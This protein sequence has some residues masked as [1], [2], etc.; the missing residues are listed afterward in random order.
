MKR[1]YKGEREYCEIQLLIRFAVKFTQKCSKIT[2]K[3]IETMHENRSYI[4]IYTANLLNKIVSLY[5][6]NSRIMFL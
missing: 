2:Y 1:R 5:I 3:I 6:K 4:V